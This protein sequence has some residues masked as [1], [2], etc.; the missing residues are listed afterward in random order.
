MLHLA[1]GRRSAALRTLGFGLA[2]WMVAAITAQA[3]IATVVPE[4]A[5]LVQGLVALGGLGLMLLGKMRRSAG[6]ASRHG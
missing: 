6:V 3:N 4:P 1:L 5:T 2:A